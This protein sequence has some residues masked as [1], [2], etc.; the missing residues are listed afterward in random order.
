MI[1]PYYQ[2]EHATI[3]HGD[4]LEIMPQLDP[5]TFGMVFTDPPYFRVKGDWW[6]NQWDTAEGFLHWLGLLAIE[7]QRLLAGNGSLY[8][9]ASPQ[10][11]AR[12]EVKLSETFNI[13]NSLVWQKPDPHDSENFGASVAGRASKEKLRAYFPNTERIVFA[14][15]F[16]QNTSAGEHTAAETQIWA[17]VFEPIRL[18]LV[19]ERDAAGLTNRQIDQHLGTA[20]MAGH[21]FGASQ[22]TMPTADAYAKIQGLANGDHFRTEYEHFRTEYEHFRTE[23]EHLRTEYE[24]LRRP[25]NATAETPYTDVWRFAS[26]QGYEGKHPCEKPQ[27]LIRHAITTSHRPDSLPIL[28]TFAGTGSTLRAAKDLGRQSV[29]IEID[30]KYCEIAANRLAQ[31]VLDFG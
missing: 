4:S 11:G 27:P 31:E 16:G 15:Q 29:G 17:S 5:N 26:V 30:E 28:D 13:L 10:M 24:H 7:W 25:F 12:V 20:G 18:K 2:D 19:K 23:Y 6:D 14:E 3:Y 9:F 8:C 22:W 1:K 21:Y